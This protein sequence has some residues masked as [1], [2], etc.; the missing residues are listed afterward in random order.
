MKRPGIVK[1]RGDRARLFCDYDRPHPPR[2]NTIMRTLTQVGLTPIAVRYDRTRRGWHVVIV[3]RRQF[4]SGEMVAL[5]LALGSDRYRERYNLR[6]ILCGAEPSNWNL[7][8]ESKL[9][10]RSPKP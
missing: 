3:F 1:E 9:E 8:F 2:L 5:Q 10:S 6:R 4:T 7:L